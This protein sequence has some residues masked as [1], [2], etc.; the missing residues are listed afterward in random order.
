[1][2]DI[3]NEMIPVEIVLREGLCTPNCLLALES[4]DKNKCSCRCGGKYHGALSETVVVGPESYNWWNQDEVVDLRGR[5]YVDLERGGTEEFNRAYR[6]SYGKFGAVI[7]TGKN[8]YCVRFDFNHKFPSGRENDYNA[9][10]RLFD[11]LLLAR[12]I[13]SYT[14]PGNYMDVFWPLERGK[15]VRNYCGI[16]FYV[17]GIKSKDEAIVIHNDILMFIYTS[18]ALNLE[19]QIERV[20]KYA[21]N[22]LGIGINEECTSAA[23]I[24]KGTKYLCQEFPVL[25][26]L[27]AFIGDDVNYNDNEFHKKNK[28][29]DYEDGFFDAMASIWKWCI[30]HRIFNGPYSI[31]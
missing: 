28:S 16:D 15:R 17:G 31:D 3:E 13:S 24:V 20:R 27:A 18:Y 19:D 30:D 6:A 29:G 9:L 4:D 2:S 26:E 21:V 5:E 12:R 22:M 25:T 7:K 23:P 10:H 11:A 8:L 1:M 14:M